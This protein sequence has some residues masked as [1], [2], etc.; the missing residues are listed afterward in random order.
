MKTNEYNDENR[1][2]PWSWPCWPPATAA[3]PAT[4]DSS[5]PAAAGISSGSTTEAGTGQRLYR[6]ER[7]NHTGPGRRW[8][9]PSS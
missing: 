2:R 9:P 8:T 6:F 1:C 7:N 5:D 3:D 4:A